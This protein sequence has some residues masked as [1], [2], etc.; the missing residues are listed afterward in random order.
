MQRGNRGHIKALQV[1]LIA[2]AALVLSACASTQ[3]AVQKAAV[4]GPVQT[5]AVLWVGNSGNVGSRQS[6][7]YKGVRLYRR[8]CANSTNRETR[9]P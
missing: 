3:P 9:S 7:S 2:G 8:S 1:A 4:T 5:K 6:R